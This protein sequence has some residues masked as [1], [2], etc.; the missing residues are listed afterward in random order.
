MKIVYFSPNDTTRTVTEAAAAAMEPGGERVDLLKAPLTEDLSVG[1]EEMLV[2][3]MP[4]YAGRIPALCLSSLTHLKGNGGPAA[5]IAVYG[6]RDYDDALLELTDLLEAQGFRVVGAGAFIAKH[7]IFPTVAANRPDEKDME[8]IAAFGRE[9]QARRSLF[10]D[11][12]PGQILVKGNRPYKKP[13]SGGFRPTGDKSCT[14]CGACAAICPT[15]SINPAEPTKTN[16]DTCIAC[17]A[18]IRVCSTGSRA[19][20]GPV[21][22][23]ARKAFELKCAAYRLPETFYRA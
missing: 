3:G 13:G 5:A 15:K 22:Q 12:H 20:R 2:V 21:Y 16:E 17:A 1:A 14:S 8:A 10:S 19:F 6:N 7:S 4:V 18:C 23:T 11:S 9:C